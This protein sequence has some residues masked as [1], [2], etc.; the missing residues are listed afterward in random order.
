MIYNFELYYIEIDNNKSEPD[1][2]G[3]IWIKGSEES[4]KRL[5][6]PLCM[7]GINSFVGTVLIFF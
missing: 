5:V 7:L 6:A 2:N 3:V 1:E 4:K